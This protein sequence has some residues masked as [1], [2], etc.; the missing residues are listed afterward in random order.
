[1]LTVKA[2][3]AVASARI[4]GRMIFMLASLTYSRQNARMNVYWLSRPQSE[5]TEGPFPLG[6][7]RAM[8]EAG[9]LPSE[10]QVCGQGEEEWMPLRVLLGM[11]ELRPVA[12]VQS[13]VSSGGAE[14]YAAMQDRD[15]AAVKACGRAV[16]VMGVIVCLLA[17]VPVLG[18][19]AYGAFAFIGTILCIVQMVKGGVRAG[20]VNLLA[21]WLVVPLLCLIFQA[22]G[23]AMLVGASR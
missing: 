9:E 2:R 20:I 23:V 8:Q 7:L 1:M 16:D 5:Q 6:R 13:P 19:L 18:W 12:S 21:V 15:A 22:I 17:F 11:E 3:A 4:R 10:A 14:F